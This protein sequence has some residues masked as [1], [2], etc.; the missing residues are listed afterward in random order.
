LAIGGLFSVVAVSVNSDWVL[1]TAL[2]LKSV[3]SSPS[4]SAA[5]D[6]PVFSNA[7]HQYRKGPK[8]LQGQVENRTI[9][10]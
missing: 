3:F 5:S 8:R 9:K 10:E 6:Q 2:P 7:Q 1:P 4:F